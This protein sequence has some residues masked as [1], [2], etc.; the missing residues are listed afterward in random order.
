[1]VQQRREFYEIASV[2]EDYPNAS[3]TAH[4]NVRYSS[5]QK[6][7]GQLSVLRRLPVTPLPECLCLPISA[8]S[9]ASQTQCN[10]TPE[11]ANPAP[12]NYVA[13]IV[14]RCDLFP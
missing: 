11:T 3:N 4:H 7:L 2:L 1:M 10:I 5:N 9:D 6:M 14:T 8:F 12:R 13:S